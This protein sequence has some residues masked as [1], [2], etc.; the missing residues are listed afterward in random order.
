MKNEIYRLKENESGL[1]Y[2][3]Y[4]NGAATL[5]NVKE[6]AQVFYSKKSCNMILKAMKNF[7][8]DLRVEVADISE[9][10]GA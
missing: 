10:S 3:L 5:T 4:D 8:Y 1:Y 9:V 7:G 2:Q 6:D